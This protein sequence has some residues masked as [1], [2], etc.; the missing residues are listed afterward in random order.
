MDRKSLVYKGAP[1]DICVGD[2]TLRILPS[3][4]FIIVFETG[5]A[6]EPV[7]EN[8]IRICRSADRGET[9]SAAEVVQRFDEFACLPS[10]VLVDDGTVTV[11]YQRHRGRFDEWTN[12][13]VR[14]TDGGRTWATPEPFAPYPERA[15]VRDRFVR[16]DGVWLFPVESFVAPGGNQP[17]IF[18]DGS[19]ANPT[20]G[21]LLTA[22]G[23]RTWQCS[24]FIRGARGWAENNV[25]E[26]ADGTIVML[27]RTDDGSG[28]LLR[29]DSADGGLTW[30][31][32][33]DSGIPNPGSK[34]RL[35]KLP[36]GRIALIH[37]PHP[38]VRHPLAL[39][40][41][42]DDLRSWRYQRVLTD[43][44]GRLQYPDGQLDE[45]GATI[46]FAFDYN[47]HDLIFW[48]VEIG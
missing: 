46:C 37:N 29:S 17:S 32:F 8:H 41:S 36:D 16:S 9:W 21:V 44:P 34:F 45:D 11:F 23:G 5:G 33:R 10:E 30:S 22:D 25:V 43:F 40:I 38:R 39:W 18:A 15:F 19:H 20:N 26:L 1:P 12:W 47:R 4:E 24:A 35:L 14:S 6:T 28:V 7:R 13:L 31:P 48:A 2:T 27:C 42:D 3:G